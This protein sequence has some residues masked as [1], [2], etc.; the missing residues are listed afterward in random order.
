MFGFNEEV[1]RVEK[2]L[3]PQCGLQINQ[4]DFVDKKS[5]REFE[6]SGLCQACQN[7]NFD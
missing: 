6:I 7:L 5:E 4:L 1:D 2:G 3:C